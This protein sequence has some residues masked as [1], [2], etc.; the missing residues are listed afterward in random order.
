[1]PHP[2]IPHDLQWHWNAFWRLSARRPSSM[3]GLSGVPFTEIAAW[4]NLTSVSCTTND[5]LLIEACDA[6]FCAAIAE[7]GREYG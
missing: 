6:A 2:D 5:I 7:R 3:G 4:V 1:M